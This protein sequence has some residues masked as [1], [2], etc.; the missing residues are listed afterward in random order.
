MF[1]IVVC[2]RMLF[3]KYGFLVI[4]RER[5]KDIKATI[6]IKSYFNNKKIKNKKKEAI[7][8]FK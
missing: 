4:M 2:L 5:L 8:A 3:M 1:Q 7:K 6:V